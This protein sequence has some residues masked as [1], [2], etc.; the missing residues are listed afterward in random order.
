MKRNALKKITAAAL[1]F[2]L[3]CGVLPWQGLAVRAEASG[4]EGRRRHGRYNRPR[5]GNKHRL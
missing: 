5:D 1:C 2:V 4:N 3:L